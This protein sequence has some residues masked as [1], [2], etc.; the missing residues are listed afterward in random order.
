M[1]STSV[2]CGYDNGDAMHRVSIWFFCHFIYRFFKFESIDLSQ[3]RFMSDLFR[4]KYRIPSTRLRMWDYA[5]QGMYFITICTANRECYF[6]NIAV[7]T[8]R[9]ASPSAKPQS[10]INEH[11]SA[12]SVMQLSAI[13]KIAEQEWLKS[14]ELRPDMNIELAEFV[15]MPNH[16]HGIVMVGENAYN[17]EAGLYAKGDAMHRVSTDEPVNKF[18]PQ[19]KNLASMMRGYKSAVT[20]AARKNET[21]FAWQERF[22]DHIIRSEEEYNRIA[23]YIINNPINWSNDKLY[24]S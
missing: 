24:K 19:S 6:G 13:G 20:T 1:N 18:G 3:T 11:T 17:G 23:G 22:H 4:N 8:R 16:F 5:N 2:D 14:V 10:P 15:V 21:P 9:I 12:Q 7:E